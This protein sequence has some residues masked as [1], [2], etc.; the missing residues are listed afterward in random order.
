[1]I[2][3]V[4]LYQ[5]S[6][7]HLLASRQRTAYGDINPYDTLQVVLRDIA[8]YDPDVVLVTGDISGDDSE[9]SYQHFVTLMSS[10]LPDTPWY[11]IPGNHDNNPFFDKYLASR[12]L[13]LENGVAVGPWMLWGIDTRGEG[14]KGQITASTLGELSSLVN[15]ISDAH[16]LLAIH[17]HPIATASW[18]DKHYLDGA[19]QFLDWLAQ[20]SQIEL[21]MHGHIHHAV[22]HKVDNKSIVSSP[23]TCWQWAMQKAFGLADE[24]P[25]YRQFTLHTDGRWQSE[26]RRC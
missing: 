15:P 10:F 19:D 1:M 7:C 25:G 17:H 2:H 16:H 8:Q 13:P 22:E 4:K 9:A 18:M 23:S 5:I 26:V 11:V 21:V 24:R 3:P 12:F 14:A 20:Q 6:D